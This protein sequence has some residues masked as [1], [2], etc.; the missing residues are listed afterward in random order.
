MYVLLIL[1][2]VP[3]L[4]FFL[5]CSSSYYFRLLN[6][7]T[8]QFY[9]FSVFRL[10][11]ETAIASTLHTFSLCPSQDQGVHLQSIGRPLPPFHFCPVHLGD[12]LS[13]TT[14]VHYPRAHN[15]MADCDH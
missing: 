14:P 9:A 12:V 10:D 11:L 2:L 5:V 4:T 8:H 1:D 13:V 6:Q 3:I 7:V 15:D